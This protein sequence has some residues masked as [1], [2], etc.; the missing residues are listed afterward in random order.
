MKISCDQVGRIVASELRAAERTRRSG[1]AAPGPDRVSLSPRAADLQAARRVLEQTPR[2][3]EERVAALRAQ[4][5][6]GTYHVPAE[7]IATAMLRD[8]ALEQRLR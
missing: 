6:A 1:Q 4:I 7:D 5:Q 8:A 2:V 3:R